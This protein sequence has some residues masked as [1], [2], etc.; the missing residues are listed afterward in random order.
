MS[1]T[2]TNLALPL[3]V[4]AIETALEHQ[5]YHPY[6]NAYAIPELRQKLITYVLNAAPVC[7]GMVE[8]EAEEASIV[9]DRTLVPK[10]VR[11]QLQE[12][13]AEGIPKVIEDNA[14]WVGHHIPAEVDA[15]LAPSDWFG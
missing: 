10:P 14:D 7:Y 8:A 5:H 12:K 11:C 4:E 13:V 1:K 2:I 3:I 6:R 15:G 9:I